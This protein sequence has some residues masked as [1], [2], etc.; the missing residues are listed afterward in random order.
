MIAA[1]VIGGLYI[2]CALILLLGVRER[3]GE[4]GV[5]RACGKCCWSF[6]SRRFWPLI[7]GSPQVEG[8]V[9]LSSGAGEVL[10]KGRRPEH[11]W[12]LLDNLYLIPFWLAKVGN[13]SQGTPG[14]CDIQTCV[15]PSPWGNQPGL[16]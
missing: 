10:R 12:G 8:Q 13:A 16:P 14:G 2:L 1:G 6:F 5:L 3:R 15:L 7:C 4:P 11:L 9:E